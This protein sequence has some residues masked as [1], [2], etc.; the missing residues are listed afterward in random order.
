M[1]VQPLLALSSLL[2]PALMAGCSSVG[3]GPAP[4]PVAPVESGWTEAGVASWYGHP[5]HGRQTAS[6]EVYD[7][8]LPTA[9]HK[10]LPFGTQVRIDNLDNGRSA[11]LRINDRGP[12]VAGRIIDVSRLGAEELGLLGPGIARV[13]VTVLNAPPPERCWEVQAGAYAEGGNAEA[14]RDRLARGG[15]QARI[16]AGPDGIHRVRV[17][18]FS[19]RRDAERAASRLGGLLLGCGARI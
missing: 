14:A 18:P 12:F 10:T 13:R 2:L 16:E 9:A 11:E 6:G 4:P 1:N 19:V 3:R 8:N 15:A 7:M 17:G 5:F